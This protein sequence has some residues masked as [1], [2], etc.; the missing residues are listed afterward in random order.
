MIILDRPQTPA[1]L[2]M[3]FIYLSLALGLEL[4]VNPD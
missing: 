3:T 2:R 4:I 1:S